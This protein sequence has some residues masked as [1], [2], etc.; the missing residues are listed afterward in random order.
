MATG[1]PVV[2]TS[3]KTVSKVVVVVGVRV[4][5]VSLAG[6]VVVTVLFVVVVSVAVVS[7]VVTEPPQETTVA[8][9]KAMDLRTLARYWQSRYCGVMFGP[10]NGVRV[11]LVSAAVV[12]ALAAF[13][14]GFP[15]AG[16]L[17]LAGVAIHGLGWLYLYSKHESGSSQ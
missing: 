9:R 10:L 5:V 8:K 4:V 13:F 11:G 7:D 17:L 2:V 14:V 6:V 3:P 12:A 16:I 15:G 1:T